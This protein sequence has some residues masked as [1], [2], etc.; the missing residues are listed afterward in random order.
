[1]TEI[2]VEKVEFDASAI[3]IGEENSL[4]VQFV[5]N[6]RPG[7]AKVEYDENLKLKVMYDFKIEDDKNNELKNAGA[8]YFLGRALQSRFQSLSHNNNK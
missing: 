6:G 3:T 4:T 8:M 7:S 1:M 2:F 5:I